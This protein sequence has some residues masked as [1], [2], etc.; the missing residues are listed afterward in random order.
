MQ[1]AAEQK[2]GPT[3]QHTVSYTALQKVGARPRS[4]TC[5]KKAKAYSTRYSQAVTH[6]S[7]DRARRCLTSQIGRDGVFSTWYGRRHLHTQL[8]AFYSH[9]DK[10]GQEVGWVPWGEGMER[11]GL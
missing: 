11:D 4:K 2:W 6:P 8:M 10:V 7:T 5:I 3:A 1:E 9:Q